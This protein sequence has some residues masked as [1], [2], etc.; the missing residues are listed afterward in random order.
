MGSKKNLKANKTRHNDIPNDWNL[1]LLFN[2]VEGGKRIKKSKKKNIKKNERKLN[3]INPSVV[4]KE[5]LQRKKQKDVDNYNLLSNYIER[6]DKQNKRKNRNREE[7]YPNLRRYFEFNNNLVDEIDE[8]LN[9]LMMNRDDY[10]ESKQIINNISRLLQKLLRETTNNLYTIEFTVNGLRTGIP[11]NNVTIKDIMSKLLH[12]ITNEIPDYAGGSDNVNSFN[13]SD[14]YNPRIVTTRRR[15]RDRDGGFFPYNNTTDICLKKYQ[16]YSKDDP[17]Y[18]LN[19]EKYVKENPDEFRKYCNISKDHCL[20]YALVVSKQFTLEERKSVK[21]FLTG[22][23]FPK[24]KLKL[25]A[26]KLGCVIKLKNYIGGKNKEYTYKPKKITKN[27]V[28]YL[29]L[30]L[31]HYFLNDIV[32]VHKFYIKNRELLKGHEKRFEAYKKSGKSYSYNTDYL[33]D[34]L[35]VIR[36]IHET[37]GFE[38]LD[39]EDNMYNIDY[40]HL[41][42]QYEDFQLLKEDCKNITKRYM[43]YNQKTKKNEEYEGE[44]IHSKTNKELGYIIH[45]DFES[46]TDKKNHEAYCVCFALEQS[47]DKIYHLYNTDP[48]KLAKK[49]LNTISQQQRIIKDEEGKNIKLPPIVY[50]HNSKYDYQFFYKYLYILSSIEQNN[51]F[52]E[53]HA[54]YFGNRIIIRDSYKLISA[55]I[56]SFSKM[57]GLECKKEAYPYELYNTSTIRQDF[58]SLDDIDRHYILKKKNVSTK[59]RLTLDNEKKQLLKNLEDLDLIKGRN[60]DHKKYSLYYCKQDVRVQMQGMMKQR[61]WILEALGLDMYQY[62]SSAGLADNY[63]IKKGCYTGVKMLRGSIRAFVQN[64]TVGGR[65]MCKDNIKWHIK[66]E[67]EDFDGVSLY[68]SAM[69]RIPGFPLGDPKIFKNFNYDYVK[70]KDYYMVEIKIKS[71]NKQLDTPTFSYK[72][73]KGTRVWS[74]E[75][76]ENNES[77]FLDKIGLEDTI[78]FHG[79]EFEIIKGIYWNKGFNNKINEEIK[80]IFNIRNK[81]KKEG[82]ALESVYKLIMNSAYG[83]TIMR[84]SST[85]ISYISVEDFDNYFNKNYNRIQSYTKINDMTYKIINY[86][87]IYDHQNRAHC[88][89]MILS[90]SKRIM[91]ELA[92]AAKLVNCPI[93]YCDTD[94]THIPKSKVVELSKMF[95]RQYGRE[96]I[97]KELGQFHGDFNFPGMSNVCSIESIFFD[98]KIYCDKLRGYDKDGKEHFSWHFRLKGVSTKSINYVCDTEFNC[99]MIALYNCNRKIKFNLLSDNQIKFEYVKFGGVMSRKEFIREIDF[100]GTERYEGFIRN[101]ILKEKNK[102]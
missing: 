84:E 98:K 88:G 4:R 65:V 17:I 16:I 79:I 93:Y 39:F 1:E 86:K 63:F 38:K 83:R 95:K 87:S 68:P 50:F 71:I 74:N 9:Q 72:N 102:D 46:T 96:L 35:G 27:I 19:D 14:I 64:F 62:L 60:W 53:V 42:N 32:P 59:T 22:S 20:V 48:E 67:I 52:F 33:T 40:N 30:Y 69:A 13:I 21:Q 82:N 15:I 45:A 101:K 10:E 90:M 56:A 37:N 94:S 31:N 75:L 54:S 77:I 47:P 85:S 66:E 24:D 12:G 61:E 25:I 5:R 28:L 92:Y 34:A 8:Q 73:K 58:L 100:D 2:I 97:G 3:R 18:K 29:G 41:N 81:L 6:L 49:F 89:A 55:P 78:N 36:L 43:R 99:D 11:I 70:T 80:Y 91:N 26:E 23:N 57:F 44:E 51:Q 76:P 7:V